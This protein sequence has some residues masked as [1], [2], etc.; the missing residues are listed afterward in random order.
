MNSG[1]TLFGYFGILVVKIILLFTYLPFAENTVSGS[2]NLINWIYEDSVKRFI[3]Q[4]A[5]YL[6]VAT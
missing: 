2:T 4:D 3:R 1:L 6:D 5:F